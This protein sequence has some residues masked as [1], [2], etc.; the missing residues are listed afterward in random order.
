LGRVQRSE[1]AHFDWSGTLQHA[2]YC[3]IF[4]AISWAEYAR[5]VPKEKPY[6][7][8]SVAVFRTALR[9]MLG[10]RLLLVRQG[11]GRQATD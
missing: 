8:T 1:K 11:K 7:G 2:E 6:G 9:N 5:I 10:L 3:P 4:G